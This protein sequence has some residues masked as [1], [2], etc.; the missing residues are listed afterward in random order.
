MSEEPSVNEEWRTYQKL[1]AYEVST[2]GNVR[3]A[4]RK[5]LL[6]PFRIEGGSRIVNLY[7][8]GG[9]RSVRVARMVAET[10]IPNPQN[11]PLVGHVDGNTG[12]DAVENLKW[13]TRLQI[14]FIPA[15]RARMG[16]KMKPVEGTDIVTCT[17]RTFPSMV[18]AVAW[19]KVLGGEKNAAPSHIC[20]C[21]R[22]RLKT[23]YGY[24]WEY[25]E[26]E[27]EYGSVEVD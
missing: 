25:V 4:K 3:N 13:M 26:E 22:G 19:L 17:T 12:N 18:D 5:N 11:L 20:E 1:P 10:F 23:A 14:S 24:S 7:V 27:D 15:I 2:L 8:K 21:C 9:R 6:S 16:G